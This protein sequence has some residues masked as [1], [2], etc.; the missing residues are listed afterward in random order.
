MF[1]IESNLLVKVGRLLCFRLF[2]FLGNPNIYI[3]DRGLLRID[4]QG[5][6]KALFDH[7][8]NMS[9]DEL[10]ASFVMNQNNGVKQNSRY[11]Y[12]QENF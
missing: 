8:P 3:I 11:Q 12:A 9:P 5:K 1:S 4:L 10:A 6:L 7:R 2:Q